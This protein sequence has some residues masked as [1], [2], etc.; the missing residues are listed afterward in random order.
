MKVVIT[1]THQQLLALNRLWD[2]ELAPSSNG[3]EEV[4]R[5]VVQELAQK[6]KAKACVPQSKYRISLKMY[7]ALALREVLH[8]LMQRNLVSE[9]GQYERYIL[10]NQYL[11]LDKAI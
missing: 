1:Y 10:H 4:T 5:L 8:Q 9:L 3:A 2:I 11:T 7:Q 6:L